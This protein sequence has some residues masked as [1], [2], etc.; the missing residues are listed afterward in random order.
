M[1]C[2]PWCGCL[3]NRHLLKIVYCIFQSKLHKWRFHLN[4]LLVLRQLRQQRLVIFV[5]A[6]L[7]DTDRVH[8]RYASALSLDSVRSRTVELRKAWNPV[9]GH[10]YTFGYSKFRSI[11]AQND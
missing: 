8:A 11:I 10:D 4:Q 3:R 6:V 9:V 1:C 7:S 5:Y 2:F